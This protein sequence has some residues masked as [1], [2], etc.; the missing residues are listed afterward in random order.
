MV[1]TKDEKTKKILLFS[2]EEAIAI[3]L[4][5]EKKYELTKIKDGIFIL[6]EGNEKEKSIPAKIVEQKI[7][8][9][10]K[11]TNPTEQKILGFLKTF[12]LSDLVEGNFEKKLLPNEI[13]IFEELLSSKKIEKFKLNKSYKKAIYRETNPTLIKF[14]NAEKPF[15]EYTLEKDGFLIV[16]NEERAKMLSNKFEKEIKDGTIKGTRAFT[17]EFFIITN[18]LLKILQEKIILEFKISKNL[19]LEQLS[20]KIGFTKSGIQVAIE[21]LKEDGQILEKRKEIYQYIE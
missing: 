5:K 6:V 20:E 12:P 15:P 10:K 16:K 18:E 11:E 3:G 19:T 7:D 1:E 14:E 9:V 2:K 13:K 8:I 4:N 21:F 17:G